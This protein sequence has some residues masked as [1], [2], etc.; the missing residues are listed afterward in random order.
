VALLCIGLYPNIC[1][2]KEKR[3]VLT[4]D[5]KSALIHKSSV[6]IINKDPKFSSPYFVFGE[7]VS[8]LSLSLSLSLSLTLPPFLPYL[9]LS[10][11]I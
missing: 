5:N 6:N 9:S 7:K 8:L 11:S 4:A 1:F 3:K 10:L 2:H